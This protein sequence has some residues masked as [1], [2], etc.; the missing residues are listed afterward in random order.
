[1]VVKILRLLGG[2]HR[3][4]RGN[5]ESA[6]LGTS[7]L[8]LRSCFPFIKPIHATTAYLLWPRSPRHLLYSRDK[9]G[10]FI[11]S[12]WCNDRWRHLPVNSG[13]IRD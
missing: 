13:C 9:R 7:D 4:S 2:D 12:G 5:Q 3:A 6:S 1:M 10:L 11:S 8:S